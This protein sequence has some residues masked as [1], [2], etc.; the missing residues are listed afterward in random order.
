ML[1][2]QVKLKCKNIKKTLLLKYGGGGGRTSST[3]HK[4]RLKSSF[5]ES[6]HKC[7]IS[8]INLSVLLKP[9]FKEKP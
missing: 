3:E 1:K 4:E 5:R 8:T 9:L 2:V 6:S 7:P